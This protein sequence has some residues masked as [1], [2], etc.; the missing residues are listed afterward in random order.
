MKGIL[1]INLGSPKDLEFE[2][3]KDYEKENVNDANKI[4]E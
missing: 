2:S 3:I 1:L 4:I